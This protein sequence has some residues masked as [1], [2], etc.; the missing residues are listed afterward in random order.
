MANVSYTLPSKPQFLQAVLGDTTVI[1]YDAVDFRYLLGAAYPRTGRIGPGTAC[2]VLASTTPAW[3][4]EINP[5]AMILGP[6]N[7]TWHPNRYLVYVPTKT[8]VNVSALNLAPTAT[9]VHKI[10][11]TI[12]DKNVTP[13]TA[14]SARIVVMEDT[15]TGAP[16]PTDASYYELMATLTISPGTSAISQANLEQFL[17]RADGAHPPTALPLAA[18]IISAADTAGFSGGPPT[19]S[20]AGNVVRYAGAVRRSSLANFTAGTTYTIGTMPS[21]YKPWKYQRFMPATVT[22]GGAARLDIQTDGT[23]SAISTVD[24]AWI[25]L[26]GATYDINY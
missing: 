23:L 10:F 14:Y 22:L 12:D 18:G 24:T 15:G 20:I 17:R 19:Y 9:R 7:T 5:G 16:N 4:I 1:S 3:T 21:G 13:A 11:A 6:S 2:Y 26:D 8:T 25:G